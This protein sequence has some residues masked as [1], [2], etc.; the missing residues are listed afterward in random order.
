LKFRPFERLALYFLFLLLGKLINHALFKHESVI[1]F[2]PLLFFWDLQYF[3]S[4]G[5]FDNLSDSIDLSQYY[6]FFN[7][8][9]CFRWFFQLYWEYYQ[10]F[11]D[12]NQY[13]DSLISFRDFGNI[14]KVSI[15]SFFRD[16]SLSLCSLL[17]Q[18]AFYC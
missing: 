8:Y 7:C 3:I 16:C 14:L 5:S 12:Y 13:I 18:D 6:D 15:E 9:W 2:I 17:F 10:D 1:H 4:I 11:Q